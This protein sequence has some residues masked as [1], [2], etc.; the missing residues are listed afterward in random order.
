MVSYKT[1][2]LKFSEKGEKSGWTYIEVPADIAERL[3]PGNK[4][5]FRVKGKLDDFA[6]EGATLLPMGG[7]S[8]ILAL[9]AAIRKGIAKKEG[10]MLRVQLEA[11]N[12]PYELDS[13]LVACLEEDAE[14]KTYFYA[15]PKS[16]QHYYSKWIESA[17]TTPT[18]EKRLITCIAALARHMNY[19]E[20]IREQKA[21]KPG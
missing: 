1:V 2:I 5:S 19:G 11:D 12:R 8:F 4:K 20:M 9:N 14:A 18:R 16:M 13:E 15:L 17:K 7:G 21:N 6:I 3:M 10:A